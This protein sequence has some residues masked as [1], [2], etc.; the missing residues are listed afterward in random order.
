MKKK[1]WIPI[2]SVIVLLAILFIPFHINTYDDGGTREYVALTYKIVAWNR[3]TADGTYNVT[4]VYFGDEHKKSIDELW[5]L[6]NNNSIT[7]AKPVIY[8]YPEEELEVSVKLT[9]DGKLT[10]T[11][12][13]Y[14]DGWTVTARPDGT[15][16]DDAGNTYNYLYW[17]SMSDVEYDFSKGF[18][19]KGEDT[20]KFLEEALEKL[21]LNRRDANEF[22]V[23]WLPLMQENP[24]NV[25]SFQ[26]DAYT[27]AAEL[28]IDPAPDTLIR[29][30]MAW[31]SS[32]KAVDIEEQELSSPE[33]V[34]FT[35]V[36]WGGSEVD[37]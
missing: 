31:H 7:N 37:K 28:D 18:C 8:L 20:A 15:L 33:R 22:I 9:V 21:G 19:I 34:G 4:K 12:P 16:V 32:E 35:V 2:L 14:G 23:Y 17:E 5:E 36:E 24:Y 11:Y 6:E 30:F 27:D 13:D 26:S 3:I 10:C 29:V 25:I 1:I